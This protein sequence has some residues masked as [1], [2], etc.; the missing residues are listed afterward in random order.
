MRGSIIKR[1]NSYRIKV[2]LGKDQTTGKYTSYFETVQGSKKETEQ[3]L[4]ELLTQLD[5]GIFVKP[6][7]LSVGEYLSTWLHDYCMP[8]LSPRTV[9]L[10]SYMNRVHITPAIGKYTLTELKPQQLQKMYSEKIASGLSPRTVQICHVVIHKAL[11]TAV[12]INLVSRNVAESVDK[13]RIQRPEMHPMNE[14]D[15]VRFLE[16]AKTGSYYALFFTYL[17]T[18]MRR[19]E[20]LAV[21]WSDVDL[22]GMQISVFRTMQYLN[23]VKNHISFKD[24]KSKKSRRLLSL[25]P[26][27]V[28]VLREH[29]ESMDRQRIDLGLPAL[30][31]N[32]LVF[33]HWD[34]SPLLPDSISHAWVKLTKRCGLKGIRLHDARHTHATIMLKQGVHPKIVQERLGHANIGTTL[35]IYSHVSPGLQAAAA[36]KFDNILNRESKL[37]RELK[38]LVPNM[39]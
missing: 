29:R 24:P 34:G 5:K 2:S 18:G 26:A 25:S 17:F 16:V 37:Y 12:K 39:N 4:R 7:K 22:F 1:G 32:D 3:R 30:K 13:P 6:G 19:S 10:Y 36:L 14:D 11:K 33:C 20:L 15:L 28:N 27:N 23:K 21:R 9:E 8:S 38:E 35:D 31:D